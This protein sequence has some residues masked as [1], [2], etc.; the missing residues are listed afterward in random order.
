MDARVPSILCLKKLLSHA[1]DNETINGQKDIKWNARKQR[2]SDKPDEFPEKNVPP[3]YG[4]KAVKKYENKTEK[5]R[6]VKAG[7]IS[8]GR[9]KP[10]SPII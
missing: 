3:L 9:R 4:G 6:T 2:E 5:N 1:G 7:D 8:S 10:P